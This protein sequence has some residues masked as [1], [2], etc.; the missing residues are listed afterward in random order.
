MNMMIRLVFC[1]MLRSALD[2]TNRIHLTSTL[3][4]SGSDNSSSSFNARRMC[5]LHT[6]RYERM[7]RK[8]EVRKD[9][10]ARTITDREKK[11]E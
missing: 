1:L 3:I 2:S 11:N 6:N 10:M 8:E 5:K 4:P 7:G 9:E